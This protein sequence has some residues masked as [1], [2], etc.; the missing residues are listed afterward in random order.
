[1]HRLLLILLGCLGACLPSLQTLSSDPGKE[2]VLV[3]GFEGRWVAEES[4]ASASTTIEIRQEGARAYRLLVTM[5]DDDVSYLTALDGFVMRIGEQWVLDTALAREAL[6]EMPPVQ[7]LH[8]VPVHQFSRLELEGDRL[9]LHPMAEEFANALGRDSGLLRRELTH[10]HT[11][12]AVVTASPAEIQEA[13]RKHAGGDP[14]FFEMDGL[15]FR[16]AP[17]RENPR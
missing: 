11:W 8:L 7:T 13:M 4:A 15:A 12:D 5:R 1:M 10:T 3:P 9:V 14:P 6:D 16:R 2:A 17:A